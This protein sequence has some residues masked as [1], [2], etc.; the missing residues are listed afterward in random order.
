LAI[1]KR[2]VSPFASLADGVKLYV[3]PG[4]ADVAGAPEIT[5]ATLSRAVERIEKYNGELVARPS[6]AQI[7]IPVHSPTEVGVP[8]RAPELVLNVAHEGLL[9]IW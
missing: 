2:R 5:G 3:E 6:L 7:R 8:L 9:E 1:E 4:A